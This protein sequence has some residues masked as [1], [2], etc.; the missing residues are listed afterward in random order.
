[1]KTLNPWL[2]A[3]VYAGKT[4]LTRRLLNAA[5]G[6]ICRVDEGNTRTDF[7]PLEQ[8]R[9]VSINL[10]DTPGHPDCVAEVER[11]PGV[12]DSVVLVISAVEVMPSQTRVMMQALGRLRLPALIFVS[13]IDRR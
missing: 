3:H 1:M 5:V 12:L 7:L 6:E 9:G 10:I 8:Q 11:V 2:L 13:K 4:S